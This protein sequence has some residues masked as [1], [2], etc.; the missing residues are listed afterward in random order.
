[1]IQ[2]TNKEFNR[3]LNNNG[4]S[5]VR[6]KGSHHIYY[7]SDG[8]HISIPRC[9]RCVIAQRIIKENNLKV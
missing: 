9:I 1:M 5:Y 6:T 3:I 4:F 8:K 7:N 2:Y